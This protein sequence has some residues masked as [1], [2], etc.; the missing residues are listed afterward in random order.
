M[1]RRVSVQLQ[2]IQNTSKSTISTFFASNMLS[3]ETVMSD[4]M[5]QLFLKWKDQVRPKTPVK[6]FVRRS[7]ICDF[8]AADTLSTKKWHS[9][10]LSWQRVVR[11]VKNFN[12][13]NMESQLSFAPKISKKSLKLVKIDM[14]EGFAQIPPKSGKK[15]PPLSAGWNGFRRMWALPV[16]QESKSDLN[17][18]TRDLSVQKAPW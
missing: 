9:T 10:L 6:R 17:V 5:W 12:L 4:G 7:R 15:V 2:L 13:K 3:P 1:Q 11:G 14:G 18:T 8:W 16:C